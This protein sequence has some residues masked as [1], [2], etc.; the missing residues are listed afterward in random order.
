MSTMCV[1]IL[2]CEGWQRG[3][4]QATLGFL[5]AHI[6]DATGCASGWRSFVDTSGNKTSTANPD[7]TSTAMQLVPKLFSNP[8]IAI[9][10]PQRAV[11][12]RPLMVRRILRSRIQLFIYLFIY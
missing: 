9:V 10:D 5:V 3:S 4:S 11:C 2:C 6:H 1:V 7:L 8:A 12:D